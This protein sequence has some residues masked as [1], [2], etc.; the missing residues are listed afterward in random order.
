MCKTKPGGVERLAGEVEQKVL[1][2]GFKGLRYSRDTPEVGWIPHEGMADMG[3]VHADLMG[4]AGGQLQRQETCSRHPGFLGCVVRQGR[5]A[6]GCHHS[7]ALPLARVS[8]DGAFD[9][10]CSRGRDAPGQGHIATVDVA[11]GEHCG[12]AGERRLR[13]GDHHD[14][15][16]VLVEAMDDAGP[17][18]PA[19]ARQSIAAMGEE[20]VDQRAVLVAWGRVHDEASWLVEHDEITVLEQDGEGNRLREGPRADGG[21]GVEDVERAGADGLGRVAQQ[22][23]VSQDRSGLDQGLDAGAGHD[24]DIGLQGHHDDAVCEIPVGA[25]ACRVRAGDYLDGGRPIG[26]VRI[27]QRENGVLALKALVIGMGVLIVAGVAV[28]GATLVGRMSPSASPIA[29][30]ML[31]E[32]P[33]SRIAGAALAPDRLAITVQG[34]GPDRVV[35]VDTKSGRVLGQVGLRP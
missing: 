16:G 14:A 33:G 3:E 32:P 2:A 7:H 28:I 4:P 26:L 13:L 11:G 31:E 19:Y 9:I 23:S 34:G 20:G 12:K 18:F 24:A 10:A 21:G 1:N 27:G 8:S 35:L 30:L 29:S 6:A 17:F 25:Q 22:D 5:F 15:G